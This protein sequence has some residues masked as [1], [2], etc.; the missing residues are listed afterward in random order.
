ML[1]IKLKLEPIRGGCRNLW[2]RKAL[3]LKDI[4]KTKEKSIQVS[5]AKSSSVTCL[6]KPL[7]HRMSPCGPWTCWPLHQAPA[8]EMDGLPDS[9]GEDLAL[10]N[11]H[12][13]KHLR[14]WGWLQVGRGSPRQ[15]LI[16]VSQRTAGTIPNRTSVYPQRMK[17]E[18]GGWYA[19]EPPYQSPYPSL[20]P[21]TTW[22][23]APWES[24][25]AGARTTGQHPKA[26]K[27]SFSKLAEPYWEREVAGHLFAFEMLP[28]CLVPQYSPSMLI[29]KLPML[30]LLFSHELLEPGRFWSVTE[31][32]IHTQG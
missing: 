15:H 11:T 18:C 5:W 22:P 2:E 10:D 9:A 4:L 12:P 26:T 32:F 17:H 28:R 3:N 1:K 7:A 24:S 19:V 29:T 21:P 13:N 23:C 14:S 16:S 8:K 31:L 30:R 6:L 20:P 25:G 27:A